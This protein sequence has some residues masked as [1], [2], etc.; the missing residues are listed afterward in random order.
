MKVERLDLVVIDVKD[1]DEAVKF[2][3][4]LFE[5]PF[6][7]L[8]APGQ[9]FRRTVISAN[10]EPVEE[11][12]KHSIAMSPFPEGLGLEL[13]QDPASVRHGL[14]SLAF[15]VADLERAKTE[16]REKGIRLVYEVY[17]GDYKGAVF[18]TDDTYGVRIGLAEYKGD[19]VADAIKKGLIE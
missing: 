18:N 9:K 16:M 13:I 19:N 15:K 2:F 8:Y 14:R 12:P 17:N 6:E 7:K 10:A 1:I 5:T 3:S 4:D 11:Q